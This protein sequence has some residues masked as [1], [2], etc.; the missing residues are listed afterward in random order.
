MTDS[1]PSASAYERA[2]VAWREIQ[3]DRANG[4]QVDPILR[5]A[6]AIEPPSDR[7]VLP[8]EP[9]RIDLGNDCGPVVT[10]RGLAIALGISM[11]A[12]QQRLQRLH[13]VGAVTRLDRGAYRTVWTDPKRWWRYEQ[14]LALACGAWAG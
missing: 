9:P 11:K 2:R 7:P 1:L 8:P 14:Q 3:Q 5:I 4:R 12:A 10:P 13:R 6:R